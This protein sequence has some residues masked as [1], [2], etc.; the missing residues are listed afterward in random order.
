MSNPTQPGSHLHRFT[1]VYLPPSL[2]LPHPQ[3]NPSALAL[4][5]PLLLCPRPPFFVLLLCLVSPILHPI[6][7]CLQVSAARTHLNNTG[8]R[9]LGGSTWNRNQNSGTW[10]CSFLF[11]VSDGTWF[12][13]PALQSVRSASRIPYDSLLTV[14]A[15]FWTPIP[16]SQ[17]T[18][19]PPLLGQRPLQITL[20]PFG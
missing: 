9:K 12:S 5:R 13:L 14:A 4:L 19:S 8:S 20:L 18:A 17:V 7:T 15:L 2:R 10:L 6:C 3:S 1:F 11:S 16:N